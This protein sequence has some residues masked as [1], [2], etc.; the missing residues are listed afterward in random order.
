[1]LFTG[2]LRQV[3]VSFVYIM[4]TSSVPLLYLKLAEIT[5]TRYGNVWN[6]PICQL[7]IK[8]T[9]YAQKMISTTGR[10]FWTT[11]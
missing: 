7:E 9:G 1:M 6:Q 4:S 3:T 8:M 2:T 10:I 5:V 11:Q